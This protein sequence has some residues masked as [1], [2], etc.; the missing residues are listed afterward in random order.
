M[1]VDGLDIDRLATE[2]HVFREKLE[3]IKG[4]LR[5]VPWYPY[6][7]LNNFTH[8]ASVL[9]GRRRYL[10]N[11]LNA[12][13]VLDIGSGD[14]DLSFFLESLGYR[15]QAIDFGPTNYNRM[16]GIRALK[17]ALKSGVDIV[18]SD[19]DSGI[20]FDPN[21]RY[22]AAFVFGILY[23]LK[24]PFY[25]LEKLSAHATYCFLSTRVSRWTPGLGTN[26]ADI[27]V[28]Y[29]VGPEEVNADPTNFWMFSPAGLRR[30]CDRANWDVYDIGFL[31]NTVSSD[32]VSPEGDERA[33]CLLRSRLIRSFDPAVELISGWHEPADGNWRWTQ[34]DFS[35]GVRNYG[36]TDAL[37]INICFWAPEQ[38]IRQLT[39]ITIR[40]RIEGCELPPQ[41]FSTPGQNIYTA[42]VPTPKDFT[43]LNVSLDRPFVPGGAD[44]R[45]LGL[46]VNAI[47]V[48]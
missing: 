18:E 21:A 15:V 31:G 16:A 48:R 35:I 44:L 13:R 22:D 7:S 30:L 12:G 29:L 45:E 42:T 1:P 24:N 41:T 9:T 20:H 34:K 4:T 8:L 14:G 43:T 37:Q 19:I 39:G 25:L 23:H 27:P 2:A 17:R 38:A 36:A 10:A 40:A 26:I 6:E 32:P 11:L 5:D 28:A 47:D 46:A 33:F 3:A